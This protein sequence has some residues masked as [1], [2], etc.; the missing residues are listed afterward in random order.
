MLHMQLERFPIPPVAHCRLCY[1][2][3]A[4]HQMLRAEVGAFALSAGCRE[5]GATRHADSSAGVPGVA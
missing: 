4:P 2:G 3:S 5:V 1:A